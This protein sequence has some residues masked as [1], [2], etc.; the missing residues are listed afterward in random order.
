MAKRGFIQH[1]LGNTFPAWSQAQSLDLLAQLRHGVRFLDLRVSFYNGEFYVVHGPVLGPAYREVWPQLQRFLDECGRDLLMLDFSCQCKHMT[2]AR[3][4]QFMKEVQHHLGAYLYRPQADPVPLCH[5][6]ATVSPSDSASVSLSSGS[7]VL[8]PTLTLQGSDMDATK[9]SA[10]PLSKASSVSSVLSLLG[11][12][13]SYIPFFSSMSNATSTSHATESPPSLLSADSAL[14]SLLPAT[15]D[16][17]TPPPSSLIP[18]GNTRRRMSLGWEKEFDAASDHHAQHH[19][20]SDAPSQP[21]SATPT[22]VGAAALTDSPMLSTSA[23]PSSPS[24]N[25]PSVR[26]PRIGALLTSGPRIIAFFDSDL[27]TAQSQLCPKA[28][29]QGE[30]IDTSDRARKLAGLQKQLDDNIPCTSLSL[31]NLQWTLTPQIPDTVW[32]FTGASWPRSLRDLASHINP[33]LM[34]FL[35][36]LMQS[37]Q[38]RKVNVI[39]VD[40]AEQLPLPDLFTY[41]NLSLASI[42]HPVPSSLSIDKL[43]VKTHDYDSR[44]TI[45]T[46]IKHAVRPRSPAVDSSILSA[47][48]PASAPSMP[49]LLSSILPA[50]PSLSHL[51]I[52]TPQSLSSDGEIFP[53]ESSSTFPSISLPKDVIASSQ[54][55]GSP[56]GSLSLPLDLDLALPL[57]ATSG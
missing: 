45:P 26:W 51:V 10:V 55:D 47:V 16:S 6:S 15:Q 3:K 46:S 4:R 36:S 20:G 41:V 43:E 28:W 25:L 38:L 7:V 31:Y 23:I 44:A 11:S 8:E 42:P 57:M 18:S 17:P 32:A 35:N 12:Y 1:A 30:W 53:S 21:P 14:A 39:T 19:H 22:F 13:S 37:Q 5:P 40:F 27:C 56:S 24:V 52:G 34:S 49:S 54:V 29:L 33:Q 50:I 2:E 48:S 9:T